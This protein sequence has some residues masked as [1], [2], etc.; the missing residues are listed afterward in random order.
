MA[1]CFIAFEGIDGSGKTIQVKLLKEKLQNL[2]YEV[3]VTKEPTDS[4]PIGKAIKKV[5]M[6]KEKVTNEALAL[7]F[8]ADR[9]NHTRKIIIPSLRKNEVVISDRYVYSSLAY[10]SRGS[11]SIS[12]NWL[13]I[14]NKSSIQPDLVI[15]I[16]IPPE[17][18]LLR[19]KKGQKR[20]VDD[21]YFES[22]EKQSRI[23]D[24][25]HKILN[26]DTPISFLTEYHSQKNERSKNHGF[27]QSK[28]NGTTVIKING[29]EAI[30]EIHKQISNFVL[31]MIRR[32]KIPKKSKKNKIVTER[33]LQFS[34]KE[35]QVKI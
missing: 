11:T 13:K 23:R 26:L 19:L 6:K 5:L 30:Q 12:L 28:I 35:V 1:G 25:Y 4:G 24:A 14:I 34:K 27:T 9:A 8:A 20:V 21:S 22:I 16:D 31:S 29:E 15:Y 10:Q 33:L 3:T 17:V 18:G 32:K 2:N 7:L